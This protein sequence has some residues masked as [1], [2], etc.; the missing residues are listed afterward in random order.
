MK[1]AV[2]HELDHGGAKRAVF[3]FSK[4]FAK[5]HSVDLY[6]TGTQVDREIPNVFESSYF[7]KFFPARWKGKNWRTRVYKDTFELLKLYKLHKELG[8][9]IRSKKYDFI[10]VHPSKFTQA[11]FILLFLNNI[12]K[13]YYCQE[14]LRIV[15]DQQLSK[16]RPIPFPKNIYETLITRLKKEIDLFNIR[17]ANII[18]ANSNH[19]LKNIKKAYG[20]TP[21]LCYLGVR[22]SEFK[23]TKIRKVFD[24]MFVGSKSYED[25][26]PIFNE[27]ISLLFQK[28][29]FKVIDWTKQYIKDKELIK[30][31][32]K[33][34]IVL[35]LGRNEPFGLVPLE[36]GACGLPVIAVN[37]GGYRESIIEGKTG[38]L[39]QDGKEL[40]KKVNAL[41]KNDNL[42]KKMG[43]SARKNVLTNWTW[44]KSANTILK[45][46]K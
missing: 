23:E 20:I 34:K 3:E 26:W 25:G 27:M 32:N 17:K 44:N 41:L 28:P 21:V 33:S 15:Y 19:S 18:F 7:F 4:E 14:P 2:F 5:N 6:Y 1:I 31:Y 11:P 29:N 40:F 35:S 43:I 13:L 30:A 39:V 12:K 9:K 36:A 22:G 46:A 38:Y 16:S 24:F 42:R 45:Y 10:F 37:E 8:K